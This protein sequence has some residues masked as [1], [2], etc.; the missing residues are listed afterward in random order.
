MILSELI[1]GFIH[2]AISDELLD[3]QD[4]FYIRNR[5]LAIFQEDFYE[6]VQCE[7]QCDL[8]EWVDQLIEY[9]INKGLIEAIDYQKDQLMT[10][11]M[12]LLTPYPS[13][14]NAEFWRKYRHDPESATDYFYHLSQVNDYIKTRAIAKNIF[15]K[16]PSPYGDL[17]ITINLSKPEKD[18]K[19]IELEKYAIKG[20]YPS[21]A[22][23][24][25][26]E[27]YK[28]RINHAARQNHRLI[29]L[30]L[31]GK[32]Y[33]LQYSPYQYYQ[34]HSIVL[35]KDHEPMVINRKCF[36]NLVA[37]TELFPHYF[38]GS[39]ADL[40]IVGGSILSHDHYQAGKYVFPMEKAQAFRTIEVPGYE[41][42]ILEL[43]DWPMTAIRLRSDHQGLLID[44][45]ERILETWKQYSDESLDI[46][47]MTDNVAHNTITPI[48][49]RRNKDYELDL[50]LRN[51]RTNEQYP[52]GIFHPH[53]EVQHIKK[54]NIGLIEVMGLAILP[55]R[56]VE[57]LDQV[58][59][60]LLEIIKL[61]AVN[62]IHQSW[63]EEL[64][65]RSPKDVNLVDQFIESEIGKV[66]ATILEHAGVFKRT[67]EGEAGLLRFID[68]VIAE[69]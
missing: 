45:A 27:G 33:G 2:Q 51:N 48:A 34:E 37:L 18:P 29:Q 56:L 61:E 9:A 49:R 21:C 14:I 65:E 55:G 54:E 12:D 57:E 19:Q 38:A 63:A 35:N 20:D 32:P 47:A 24:M 36:E 69:G 58:K 17:D 28:G 30:E 23:C 15:F 22:L 40:P 62:P 16:A 60:Y 26:N 46:I 13:Q 53:A 39:N 25:E 64:K 1:N 3:K 50:V 11:I 42:V 43:V 68:Q 52:A 44:L 59:A 66:Y 5:L 4:E 10:Q 41:D 8:L 7:N 6:N 31:K 67:P